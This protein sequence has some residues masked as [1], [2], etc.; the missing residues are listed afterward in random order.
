MVLT[1]SVGALKPSRS[2]A[3]VMDAASAAVIAFA[4]ALALEIAPVRVNL[5]APG[6]IG[7]VVW[8]EEGR[9]GF[10]RRAADALLV[11]RLGADDDLAAAYLATLVNPYMTGS[12][13]TMDGGLRLT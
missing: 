10:E 5:I 2:G 7:T 12:V 4:R 1:S 13:S 8:S 11:G 6:V 3:S 9:V